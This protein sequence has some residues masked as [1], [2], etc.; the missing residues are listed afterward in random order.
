MDRESLPLQSTSAEQCYVPA[1]WRSMAQYRYTHPGLSSLLLLSKSRKTGL[2]AAIPPLYLLSQELAD[3]TGIRT[4]KRLSASS[5][6][7]SGMPAGPQFCYLE[8]KDEVAEG[9]F[10]YPVC[11]SSIA[12]GTLPFSK[13]TSSCFQRG[14]DGQD[15]NQQIPHKYN[16]N[17][18]CEVILKSLY[19]KSTLQVQEWCYPTTLPQLQ[20]NLH[21]EQLQLFSEGKALLVCVQHMPAKFSLCQQNSAFAKITCSSSSK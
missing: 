16:K 13:A 11:C 14:N 9:H 7:G 15:R 12:D 10:L 19:S 5:K 3:P 4:A 1:H 20:G 18:I 17:V 6:L 8:E 21:T 2:T